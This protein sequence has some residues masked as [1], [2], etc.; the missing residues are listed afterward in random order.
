MDESQSAVAE[1]T[2]FVRSL[3]ERGY[4]FSSEPGL[5]TSS[6]P[7]YLVSAAGHTVACAVMTGGRTFNLDSFLDGFEEAADRLGSLRD[8]GLPLVVVVERDL[9]SWFFPDPGSRLLDT[10]LHGDVPRE[11]YDD[12]PRSP[13]SPRGDERPERR[14]VDAHPHISALAVVYHHSSP[15]APRLRDIPEPFDPPQEWLQA[16]LEALPEAPSGSFSSLHL[17]E[18]LGGTAATLP[19][20]VFD[21]PMD[22]RWIPN[23]DRTRL[24]PP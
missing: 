24:L 4:A 16:L 13:W 22:R 15:D 1:P 17:L 11:L 19:R 5:A 3:R 6:G 8:R 9:D 14:L 12:P 23:D 10:L 20:E 21:G 18:T 2:W 7:G